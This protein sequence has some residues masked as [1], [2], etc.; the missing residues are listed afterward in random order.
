MGAL[1]AVLLVGSIV[2][3]DQEPLKEW[4]CGCC[5]MVHDRDVAAAR[6]IL[7]LGR[8]ALAEGGSALSA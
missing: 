5:G 3:L 4:A 8:Q 2:W 7:R 1:G 6:N